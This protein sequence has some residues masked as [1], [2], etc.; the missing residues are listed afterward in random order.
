MRTTIDISD[1]LLQEAKEE[2]ARTHRPLRQVVEDALRASLARHA[3]SPRGSERVKLLVSRQPAGLCPGV[4]LDA[5]AA[6]LELM[7]RPN[8]PPRR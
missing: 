1:D 5:S 6:L 7:E 3:S 2:A 8:G 4:D